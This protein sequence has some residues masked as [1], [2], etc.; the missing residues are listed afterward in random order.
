MASFRPFAAVAVFASCVSAHAADLP[1]APKLP[2]PDP[3][4]AA[5]VGGGWYLRGDVGIGANAA[6]PALQNAPDPLS[7][8]ITSGYISSSASQAFNNTTLSP[9]GMVDVGAGY[10]F[11]DWFRV[12]GTFEYR[13]GANLQS[14]YTLTDPAS[15]IYGGPAQNADFYRADVS[16]YVGLVN[17]Y[18]NVGSWFGISPFIGAGLGVADNKVGGFTDQNLAFADYSALGASGGYFGNGSKT[19]FAW[20]LMAGLDFNVSR[21]LKLEF[22]YRYLNYGSI[23]TG[24]SNCLTGGS[25]GA[26]SATTCTGGVSHSISSSNR[27]A[28][29]D[30]RLGLIYTLGEAPPA[31]PVV[32]RY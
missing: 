9:F 28:S 23:A 30:F 17:G 20:A 31:A 26:F 10:R 19:A 21:N 12:D 29:N 15:P 11:N 3:A 22:S 25:S 4:P 5:D 2:P 7:A 27:L 8:G 14:L 32:A 18:V 16:S 1:P 6:A 24:A 13:G